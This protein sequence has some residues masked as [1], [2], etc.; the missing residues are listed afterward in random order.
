MLLRI[1]PD[2][3]EKWQAVQAAV[4]T[5]GKTLRLCLI[6]LVSNIPL[7]MALAVLVLALTRH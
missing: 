1:P 2:P 7:G 6:L 3:A 4:E 5:N